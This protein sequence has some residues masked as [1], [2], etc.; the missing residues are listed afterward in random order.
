[1]TSKT[2]AARSA[3]RN[4]ALRLL[5]RLGFG[6]NGLLHVVIGL[7]AIGV[8]TGGGQDADQTG[9]LSELASAPGGTLLLWAVTLGLAA[10]GLWLAIGAFLLP[11]GDKKEVAAHLAKELGKAIAYLALAGTAFTFALGGS[12]NSSSSTTELSASLLAAPGG[13][14]LVVV[15]GLAVLAIGAYFVLKGATRRFTRDIVVPPGRAGAA[16]VGIGVAGYVAKGVALGVVGILFVV[17]AVTT[18]PSQATGLDGALKA[19]TVLPFGS[20]ALWIVG[21]G[22][23]AYGAF[24]GV[25]AIRARL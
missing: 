5:A 16:T 18:D 9:A 25:R 21:A 23:I 19:F 24:C 7:I 22:L 20:V 1:M 12:S 4:P 2:Q 3:T 15:I 11:P 6:V 8:A 13:V 10:L 17:A 14:F